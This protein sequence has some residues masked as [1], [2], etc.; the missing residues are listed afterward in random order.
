MTAFYLTL[1]YLASRYKQAFQEDDLLEI[2]ALDLRKRGFRV[3]AVGGNQA[4][5]FRFHTKQLKRKAPD[6]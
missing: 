3:L 5:H 2:V 4:G 6:I 1:I